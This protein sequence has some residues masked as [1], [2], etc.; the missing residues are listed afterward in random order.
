MGCLLPVLA[1]DIEAL[2][3]IE[4]LTVE[5][6]DGIDVLAV[7]RGDCTQGAPRFVHA[8]DFEPLVAEEVVFLN[9]INVF[10][11]IVTTDC[12]YAIREGNGGKCSSGVFHRCYQ[13]PLAGL[14]IETFSGA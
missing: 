8:S 10:L 5:A 12:I 1:G 4:G 13:L 3:T 6:S 9:R 7:W 14:E 2:H 11:A